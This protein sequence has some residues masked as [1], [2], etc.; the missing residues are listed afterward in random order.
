MGRGVAQFPV[1]A[2][3]KVLLGQLPNIIELTQFFDID[4]D[5]DV[6]HYSK[7]CDI[8]AMTKIEAA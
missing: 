2:R 5:F 4:T 3:G 6:I 7:Q 1:L 8:P